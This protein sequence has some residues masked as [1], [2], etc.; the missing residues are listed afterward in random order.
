MKVMDGW[1]ALFADRHATIKQSKTRQATEMTFDEDWQSAPAQ[2]AR[3]VF[4]K[5]LMKSSSGAYG[6]ARISRMDGRHACESQDGGS[7]S[8][9]HGGNTRKWCF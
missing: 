7:H 5:K 6:L 2:P 8:R 9:R 4:R 1:L 3:L